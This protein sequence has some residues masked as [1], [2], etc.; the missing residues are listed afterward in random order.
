MILLDTHTLVWFAEGTNDLGANSQA[1]IEA[2]IAS[3]DVLIP[4]IVPLEIA[5]LTRRERIKLSRP[6]LDWLTMILSEPAFRLAALEPAI[7][8]AAA[9]LDWAHRDPMD[10]VIVATARAW[11]AELVTADRKILAYAAAGHVQAIDARH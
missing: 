2:E 7:A 6:T 3:G 1:R 9:E 10:R 4:A 5:Q 8:V 11:S